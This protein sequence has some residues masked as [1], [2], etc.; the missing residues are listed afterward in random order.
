MCWLDKEGAAG[1]DVRCHRSPGTVKIAALPG[2]V[3]KTLPSRPPPG[4]ARSGYVPPVN[5]MPGL[6]WPL[7]PSLVFSSPLSSSPVLFPF[8][9][10]SP[11]S[12][13]HSIIPALLSSLPPVSFTVPVSV[14]FLWFLLSLSLTSNVLSASVTLWHLLFPCHPLHP[15]A[16][17]LRKGPV[18][19]LWASAEPNI[20]GLERGCLARGDG[21]LSPGQ[22]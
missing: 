20:M 16:A 15:E 8:A 11:C 9:S 17:A 3:Q 18:L 22:M 19:L 1:W 10:T 14:S 4:A 2:H 21:R 12:F 7:P 6:R 13:L 5:L